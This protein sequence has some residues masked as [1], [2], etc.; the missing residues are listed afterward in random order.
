MRIIVS[1]M[2]RDNICRKSEVH[3]SFFKIIISESI[4]EGDSVL[5]R[6]IRFKSYTTGKT[7]LDIATVMRL[8]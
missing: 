2:R 1:F 4:K 6:S 3:S 8:V 7:L 5:P